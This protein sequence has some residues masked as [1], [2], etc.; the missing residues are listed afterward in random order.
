MA[1]GRHIENRSLALPERHIV[2]LTWNSEWG[3]RITWWQKFKMANGR[4]LED[5][6]FFL[7]Q[8]RIIRFRRNLVSRRELW[9]R[10]WSSDEESKFSKPKWRTDAI[11]KIVFGYIS[12]PYCPMNAKFGVK[13]QNYTQ[14]QLRRDLN[15]KFRK[16]KMTDGRHYENGYISISQ[17]RIVRFRWHLVCRCAVSF[18]VNNFTILGLIRISVV[19]EATPRTSYIYWLVSSALPWN[20]KFAR[21]ERDH[22]GTNYTNV[23]KYVY[24]KTDTSKTAKIM[25]GDITYA[26]RRVS[27]CCISNITVRDFYRFR[28]VTLYNV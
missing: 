8:P 2:R 15:A 22:D 19:G 17:R 25:N 23:N 18:H 6:F 16:C 14:R 27:T 7:S 10:D 4:Y 1:D 28:C 26:A 20:Q 5:G 13:K 9:F 3:S 24:V 12:E 21:S 11:L